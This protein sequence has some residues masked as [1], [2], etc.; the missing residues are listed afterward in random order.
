MRWGTRK[1]VRQSCRD[2]TRHRDD[3]ITLQINSL[4]CTS[5]FP[6]RRSA[7]LYSW[8]FIAV[9]RTRGSNIID[10]GQYNSTDLCRILEWQIL[11]QILPKYCINLRN[12][13]VKEYNFNNNNN[14]IIFP[15]QYFWKFP[16]PSIILYS[17]NH[18]R[19]ITRN[20]GLIMIKKMLKRI[21]I[22]FYITA[23]IFRWLC[24]FYRRCNL[25]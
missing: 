22:T 25:V 9:M 19:V 2:F 11:L 7:V 10:R 8:I 6:T 24:R 4:L 5:R 12:I 16:Y 1:Y 17:N 21:K 14:S 18:R 13:C 20:Y 15:F 3:G 23:E